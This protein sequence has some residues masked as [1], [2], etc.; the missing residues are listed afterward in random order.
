MKIWRSLKQKFG[1]PTLIRLKRSYTDIE[2][3]P[4]YNWDKC[5][6]GDF[7]FVNRPRFIYDHMT[8]KDRKKWNM[9][10]NQY[11]TMFGLDEMLE[12]FLEIQ[13][14]LAELRFQYIETN[15]RMLLNQIK[16]EEANLLMHDPSRI[17]GMTI[18]EC[19]VHL[20]K[21]K[22][23]ELLDKKKIT[24]VQFKTLMNTYAGSNKKE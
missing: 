10:F 2:E 8:K 16:I 24:I 11:L 12:K 4:L 13:E 14:Y 20:S 23:G 5:Q 15:N 1:L 21:W 6:Q 17:N 3:F 19:L 7:R 9:L 22:G 18:D